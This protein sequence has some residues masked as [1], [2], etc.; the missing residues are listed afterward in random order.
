MTQQSRKNI[1]FSLGALALTV[2]SG[3]I[4]YQYFSVNELGLSA[5]QV[6]QLESEFI[7]GDTVAEFDRF[8]LTIDT[9]SINQLTVGNSTDVELLVEST[10]IKEVSG[11]EIIMEYDP[12]T[13]MVEA[14]T[15]GSM[16]KYYLQRDVNK[17]L[18]TIRILGATQVDDY[19]TLSR[20][21]LGTLRIKRL[22]EGNPGF[23][24]IGVEQRDTKDLISKVTLVN[25]DGAVPIASQT[26]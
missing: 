1:Y 9:Q 19:E 26:F 6:I 20:H 14:I 23:R 24:T 4:W 2:A 13:I 3:Y 15:N 18:G 8:K 12:R 22:K 7:V 17:E 16:F 11:I 5:G 10:E 25:G 21:L